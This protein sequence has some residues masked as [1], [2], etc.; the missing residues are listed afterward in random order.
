MNINKGHVKSIGLGKL[1]IE[2]SIKLI[3]DQWIMDQ[4][5]ITNRADIGVGADIAFNILV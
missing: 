4:L 2:R 1:R 5:K 3:D